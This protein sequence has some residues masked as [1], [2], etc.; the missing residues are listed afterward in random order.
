[1]IALL[2]RV[3]YA[4]VTVER[5]VLAKIGRGVLV[6]IGVEQGDTLKHAERLA[7]RI[8]GYRIFADD[9]DR[10]NLSVKDIA[11]DLLLVPQF[12]LAADTSSGMRPSFTTA[13]V[14]NEGEKIFNYCLEYC[15]K[16]YLDAKVASGKFGADMQI[17]LCNN[18]PVTFILSAK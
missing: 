9:A 16:L 3:T 1:M 2:Q 4:S 5:E 13:A 12:T 15:R 11:G 8:I 14:P 17:E 10:M 7:A 6:F 18:G